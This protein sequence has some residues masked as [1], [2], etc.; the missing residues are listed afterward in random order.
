[1]V[2]ELKRLLLDFLKLGSLFLI[3]KCLFFQYSGEICS[4]SKRVMV[5]KGAQK[6]LVAIHLQTRTQLAVESQGRFWN[7][8]TDIETIENG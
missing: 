5:L 4:V 2:N 1:M 8:R 3:N 7:K 6:D